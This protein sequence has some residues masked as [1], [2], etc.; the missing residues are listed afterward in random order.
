MKLILT[1][2]QPLNQNGFVQLIKVGNSILLKLVRICRGRF[3]AV[4]G[5]YDHC[6]AVLLSFLAYLPTAV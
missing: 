2:Q 1:A 6:A 5:W 4:F 3:S